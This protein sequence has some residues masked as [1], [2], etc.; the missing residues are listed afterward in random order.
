MKK[1]WT[2]FCRDAD[3]SQDSI[4]FE[5]KDWLAWMDYAAK[6]YREP[7]GAIA[8]ATDWNER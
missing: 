5:Q 6:N 4:P 3:L 7:L 8:T 2:D 1:T